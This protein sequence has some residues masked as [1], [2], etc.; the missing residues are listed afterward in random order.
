LTL[1][2]VSFDTLVGLFL[3]LVTYDALRN[4]WVYH[5]LFYPGERKHAPARFLT[6]TVSHELFYPGERQHAPAFMKKDVH[7]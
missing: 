6:L 5:E 7:E 1:N 3:T 4:Y 2:S